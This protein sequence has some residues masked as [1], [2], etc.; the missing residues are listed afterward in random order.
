MKN[1]Q[2]KLNVCPKCGTL[3]IIIERGRYF[4]MTVQGSKKV[5]MRTS[6][7]SWGVQCGKCEISTHLK[8]KTRSAAIKA[9]NCINPINPVNPVK[10]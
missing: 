6:I 2:L 10:K 1:N 5:L 3:A 9:F 4:R 7:E 8:H